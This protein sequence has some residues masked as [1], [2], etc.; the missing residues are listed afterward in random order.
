MSEGAG[1]VRQLHC[2]RAAGH[3]LY[4]QPKKPCDYD[5]NNDHADD[6][7]NVHFSTPGRGPVVGPK[8]DP[9]TNDDCA[10]LLMSFERVARRFG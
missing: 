4:V 8:L 5:D 2:D 10:K 3:F 6:I 9:P 7:E 1:S